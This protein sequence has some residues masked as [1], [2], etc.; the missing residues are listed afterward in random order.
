MH[1]TNLD[2]NLKLL[3]RESSHNE[4]IYLSSVVAPSVCMCRSGELVT[5]FIAKGIAFE[6]VDDLDI[7]QATNNLNILYRAVAR[8]D[9]AVQIHRLRRPMIDELTACKEDGF[10]RN[11]SKK[12]NQKIG[13]E[14]L[15]ATELYIT[16]IYKKRN[17]IKKKR[18]FEQIK[19][20][21]LTRLEEFE[22]V[23]SQFARSLSRFDVRRLSEY[24]KRRQI[25]RAAV[26]L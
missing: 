3:R 25:F 26:F 19:E 18:S 12:Y 10:A 2:E 14:R 13:H 24:E 8:S 21:L 11:L 23:A 22:K 15:M 7:E 17:L 1:D 5:T 6:T 16:L 4:Y 9:F 20:Q